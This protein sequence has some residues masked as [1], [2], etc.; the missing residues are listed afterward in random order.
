[1]SNDIVLSQSSLAT[2]DDYDDLGAGVRAA[3]P[4]LSFRGKEWLINW[5]RQEMYLVDDQGQPVKEIG[6]T[7]LK[8][9]NNVSKRYFDRPYKKGERMRPSCWSD[10]G[11]KPHPNAAIPIQPDGRATPTI[12]SACFMD[13]IGSRTSDDKTRKMKACADYKRIAVKLI[14]P[15]YGRMLIEMGSSTKWD[16]VLFPLE[17]NGVTDIPMLLSVPTASLANLREYG[18][19]LEQHKAFALGRVTWIGFVMGEAFPKLTFRHGAEFDDQTYLQMKALRASDEASFILARGEEEPEGNGAMEEAPT[20]ASKAPAKVEQA[21]APKAAAIPAARATAT[22]TPLPT[23]QP[24]KATPVTLSNVPP[25]PPP[26]IKPA[27]VPGGR[28][29]KA[30]A[31]NAAVAKPAAPPTTVRQVALPPEQGNGEKP[32]Y[33]D[34]EISDD[35]DQ[36]FQSLKL[37]GKTTD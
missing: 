34:A 30:A 37:G 23:P 3:F 2:P 36:L 32:E 15:A 28:P 29:V 31:I 5:Q 35:V 10:D 24:I 19:F 16:D 9:P 7:L 22:V 13:T 11:K 1:M 20:A 33:G 26:P 21:V 8:V 25:P 14:A 27:F 17:D 4:V 12:C 6:V 18:K